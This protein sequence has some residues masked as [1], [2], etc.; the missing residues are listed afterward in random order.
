[1]LRRILLAL[2]TAL[3]GLIGWAGAA[4]SAYAGGRMQSRSPGW[5]T[6]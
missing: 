5:P 3:L 1:M 6:M 4:G 2:L